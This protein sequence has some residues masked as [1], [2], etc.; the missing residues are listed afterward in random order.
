MFH[1]IVNLCIKSRHG[2]VLNFLILTFLYQLNLHAEQSPTKM[3]SAT[4]MYSE[5]WGEVNICHKAS[6]HPPQSVQE[7]ISDHSNAVVLY[8]MACSVS[9]FDVDSSDV[10]IVYVYVIFGSLKVSLGE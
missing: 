10:F 3:F 8:N 6:L 7:F 5:I 9:S 2:A 4:Y 1:F